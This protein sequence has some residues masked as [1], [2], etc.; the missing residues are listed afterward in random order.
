MTPQE[1]LAHLLDEVDGLTTALMESAEWLGKTLARM[2]EI[3][4]DLGQVLALDRVPERAFKDLVSEIEGHLE[5]AASAAFCGAEDAEQYIDKALYALE[6]AVKG[7]YSC[8]V[9]DVLY[10]VLD[11]QVHTWIAQKVGAAS[12]AAS[13]VDGLV[14]LVRYRQDAKPAEA[15]TPAELRA[16]LERAAP[17]FSVADSD[18]F[19]RAWIKENPSHRMTLDEYYTA[20]ITINSGDRE[21][22]YNMTKQWVDQGHRQGVSA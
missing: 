5:T 2:E 15:V 19:T 17:P 3:R 12:L 9:G 14:G 16:R 20:A 8:S 13:T 1:A 6:E 21:R 4:A 11:T 7:E 22:A 10:E 18:A